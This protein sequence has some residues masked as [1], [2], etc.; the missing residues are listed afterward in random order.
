M[1]DC[2][3]HHRPLVTQVLTYCPACRG[4]AAGGKARAKAMT[5]RARSIAARKA[6]NARWAQ[7][8]RD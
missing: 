8:A 4:S 7:R 3:T 5:K 2:P 6:V 1:P